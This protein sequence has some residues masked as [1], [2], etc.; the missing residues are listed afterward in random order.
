MSDKQENTIGESL[1]FT[2]S[3]YRTLNS[4]K[5]NQ[6]KKVIQYNIPFVL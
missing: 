3:I 2:S 6:F 4:Q 1:K 5:T